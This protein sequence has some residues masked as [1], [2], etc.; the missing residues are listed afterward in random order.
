MKIS[1]IFIALGIIICLVVIVIGI[2][3]IFIVGKDDNK[4]TLKSIA[5]KF[6]NSETKDYLI[7]YSNTFSVTASKDQIVIKVMTMNIDIF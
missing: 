4:I 3:G 6:E 5:N 2:Y 1:K 7:D